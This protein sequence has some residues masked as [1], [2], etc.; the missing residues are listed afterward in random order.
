[1]I[2]KSQLDAMRQ[3]HNDMVKRGIVFDGPCDFTDLM[4]TLDASLKV[5]EAAKD[6]SNKKCFEHAP[7]ASERLKE[8]LKPFQKE[9][10]REG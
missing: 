10:G 3:K 5:V 6:V 9:E 2:T 8:A 4:D 7:S 1:V